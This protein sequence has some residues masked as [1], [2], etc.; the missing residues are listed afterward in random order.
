M[1]NRSCYENESQM[2]TFIFCVTL[3]ILDWDSLFMYPLRSTE[4]QSDSLP[5]K[6]TLRF[7]LSPSAENINK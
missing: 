3:L 4:I 6:F 5:M 7:L 2:I 1:C